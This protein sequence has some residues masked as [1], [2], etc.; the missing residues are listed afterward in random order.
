MDLE[1]GPVAFELEM[2]PHAYCGLLELLDA[3][4]IDRRILGAQP[5]NDRLGCHP[6][7]NIQSHTPSG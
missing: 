1:L 6:Q 4:G 3:A 2:G 7:L 5:D